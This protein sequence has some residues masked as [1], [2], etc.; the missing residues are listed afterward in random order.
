MDDIDFLEDF[1]FGDDEAMQAFTRIIEHV[2]DIEEGGA[3]KKAKWGGSVPGRTAIHRDRIAGHQRLF[4]DYFSENPVYPP[5]LFRRRFRMKRDLFLQIVKDMED[6]CDYFVQKPNAAKV[7][8]FSA[9]QK[10]TAAI[11]MLSYGTAADSVDEYL[12]MAE[13][14]AIESLKYFCKTVIKVYGEQYLRSPKEDDTAKLLKE[15][16]ERGFPG[17]LG[18]IDCMHWAWKNCPTAWHG[19][20]TGKEK[21]ATIVLEAV[22]SKNLWIWHA[23]FG[24]PGSL[25]DINV[26]DRSPVFQPVLDGTA[27]AVNFVVNGNSYQTGYYLADGIYPPYATFISS[28]S[29]PITQKEKVK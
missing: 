29:A 23:F 25:N 7:L 15:G 8:G 22:A 1:L 21:Q 16:E 12:R 17:M 9:L 11:R 28:I 10:V 13:S 3:K 14:T 18:S 4:S 27:P 19:Q 20:F 24:L 5:R 2:R 6:N 26:L